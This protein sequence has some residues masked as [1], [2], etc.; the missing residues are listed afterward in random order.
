MI[1]LTT[2]VLTF[3]ALTVLVIG[4]LVIVLRRR[5]AAGRGETYTTRDVGRDRGAA[6]MAKD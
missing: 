4:L 3:V 5:A 1:S 6:T 2:M